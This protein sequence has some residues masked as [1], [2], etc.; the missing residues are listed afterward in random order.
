MKNAGVLTTKWGSQKRLPK[1]ESSTI[2]LI[3]FVE[4]FDVHFGSQKTATKLAVAKQPI[5]TN[6]LAGLDL[7][8]R[9]FPNVFA[10][11]GLD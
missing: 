10:G 6:V 3:L 2:P 11:L 4:N 7:G 1:L 5:F 8:Q 9:I